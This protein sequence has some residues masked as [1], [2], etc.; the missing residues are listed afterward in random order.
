M[1][2]RWLCYLAVKDSKVEMDFWEQ[3]DGL[4]YKPCLDFSRE[5]RRESEGVGEMVLFFIEV[6]FVELK[7]SPFYIFFSRP[8]LG[9]P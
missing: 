5:Y 8:R 3:P 6:F 2:Y 7:I 1:A 9:D 4:G